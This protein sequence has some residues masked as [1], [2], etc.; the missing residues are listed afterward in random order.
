MRYGQAEVELT[1]NAP[2]A[3]DER[4]EAHNGQENPAISVGA[5]EIGRNS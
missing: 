1:P 2:R 4:G 3:R 5:K